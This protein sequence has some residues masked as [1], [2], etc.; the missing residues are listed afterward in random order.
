MLNKENKTEMKMIFEIGTG[1][2]ISAVCWIVLPFS[3]FIKK[4]EDDS[5]CQQCGLKKQ[6]IARRETRRG[7][8]NFVSDW[9]LISYLAVRKNCPCEKTYSHFEKLAM[10]ILGF[11]VYLFPFWSRGMG[12]D[13]ML[14]GFAAVAMFFLSVVDWN[15]Q[16]IPFECN[17]FI[18]ICGLIHLFADFSN[19]LEYLIGL[20]AVSGFLYIVNF[21]ATPI[22][23]KRYEEE[24][25]SV[26]GDGDIKL[27]AATGLLLGWKLN[28]L[29][30]GIGCI[31][32]SVIHVA[33]MKIK[34]SNRQFAFG[35]YLSLGIY[36]TMI[37]G[38]Q[39]VSWYLEILGVIPY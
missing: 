5:V 3:A 17:I 25:D 20:I 4:I 22:L 33:L 29:A 31:A 10:V 27:M 35:P 34:G 12:L 21:V 26:I 32:G 18:F 30:L 13:G 8:S 2:I 11:L 36:I 38:T 9:M 6:C 39:L 1:L 7:Q 16:Y 19:W 37:C 23:R 24:I 15:T 14:M 28:F